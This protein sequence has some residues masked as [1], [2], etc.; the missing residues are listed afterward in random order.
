MSANSTVNDA[1]GMEEDV[2]DSSYEIHTWDD[3]DINKDL[4]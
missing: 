3:L 2:Y 4:L 1:F